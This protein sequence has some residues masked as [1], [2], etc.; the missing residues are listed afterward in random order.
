MSVFKIRI[1]Y[2]L[3]IHYEEKSNKDYH[4]FRALFLFKQRRISE[5]SH[6]ERCLFKAPFKSHD[7]DKTF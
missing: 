4:D 2:L 7:A 6:I 5:C 1:A 3:V